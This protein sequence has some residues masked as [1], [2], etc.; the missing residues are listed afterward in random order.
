MNEIPAKRVWTV[1]LER[2]GGD[3]I[4]RIPHEI[5]LPGEEAVL[6]RDGDRVV[7]EAAEG[8]PPKNLIEYLRSIPPITEEFPKID[9][10]FPKDVEI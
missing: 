9:D 4:V 8:T 5:A 3:Q 1:K 6:R 2:S 7:V 10:P